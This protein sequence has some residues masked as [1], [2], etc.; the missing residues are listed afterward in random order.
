MLKL[1]EYAALTFAHKTIVV[2]EELKRYCQEVYNKEAVYIPNGFSTIDAHPH[3]S[4]T[5]KFGL[6]KGR[7]I[8][9]V[10]RLIRHKGVHHLIEAYKKL[11]TKY[12]L[13]IV[14]DGYH[15]SDYVRQLKSMSNG[16]EKIRFLGF[17]PPEV[18][19][20]LFR[21]AYITAQPSESEGLPITV[22]ESMSHGKAVVGSDIAEMRELIADEHFLFQNRNSNDLQKKLQE[23]LASPKKV[24]EE[25]AKRKQFVEKRYSWDSIVPQVQELYHA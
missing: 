25:G 4:W 12:P 17:Q 15:T 1:G 23:L 8:L 20:D 6:H 24:A 13:V 3:D 16:E 9:T 19:A 14:G 18:L 10:S 7:F 2:S 22:L 5:E 11:K 21:D